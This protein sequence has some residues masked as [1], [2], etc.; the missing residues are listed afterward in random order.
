MNFPKHYI[1][2]R[3]APP[4]INCA[5]EYFSL[6]VIKEMSESDVVGVNKTASLSSTDHLKVYWQV[7]PYTTKPTMNLKQEVQKRKKRLEEKCLYHS[8]SHLKQDP[9]VFGERKIRMLACP[10][11]IHNL[12]TFRSGLKLQNSSGQY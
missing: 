1:Y 5:T 7:K 10:Q 11:G 8:N 9:K 12:L 2:L 4:V 6:Q 3:I